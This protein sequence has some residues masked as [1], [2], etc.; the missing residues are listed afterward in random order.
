MKPKD[1]ENL[2]L[3][4]PALDQTGRLK[5]WTTERLSFIIAFGILMPIGTLFICTIVAPV[6]CKE[7]NGLVAIGWMETYFSECIYTPKDLINFGIGYICMCC[8]SL[9]LTPQIILNYV[10]GQAED[11]SFLFY[12]LWVAGDFTNFIGCVI[13]RQLPTQIGVA[14][15]Y[16]V[17]TLVLLLQYIYYNFWKPDAAARSPDRFGLSGERKVVLE[18]RTPDFSPS[19]TFVVDEHGGFALSSS[20]PFLPPPSVGHGNEAQ[21]LTSIYGT[22]PLDYKGDDIDNSEFR[23]TRGLCIG[24]CK[25]LRSESVEATFIVGS[26]VLVLFLTF[27]PG[28]LS[29][30]Q[31]SAVNGW[32]MT[33]YYTISRVPQ[34][35]KIIKTQTVG[36]LSPIMFVMTTLGNL[37]YIAQILFVSLDPEFLLDKIPWI[38]QALL[39][40]F[41]DMLVLTLYAVFNSSAAKKKRSNLSKAVSNISF[42]QDDYT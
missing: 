26:F 39:C 38:A 42:V 9:C 25:F 7:K 2:H 36:G 4:P 12:L 14:V 11:Q 15:I 18:S 28:I 22:N 8:W 19:V 10:L 37:T 31:A 40:I 34:I 32:A 41:Q 5:I 20:K 30:Y 23:T 35:I 24:L 33:I 13:A 29:T 6:D 3:T 17:L 1:M 16:L 27:A 21:E